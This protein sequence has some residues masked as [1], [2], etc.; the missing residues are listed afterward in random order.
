MA[1]RNSLWFRLPMACPAQGT[2][3]RRHDRSRHLKPSARPLDCLQ[4]GMAVLVSKPPPCVIHED[5]HILVVN[6]PAG[7]NTHSPAPYAG[8]GIYEWLRNRERRWGD[9]AIIHRLDKA[10]SGLMLFAKTPLAN[11][12]LTEQFTQRSVDKRYLFLTSEPPKETEFTVRASLLRAGEK[13][14][15]G[16]RGEP[17]ETRFRYLGPDREYYLFAAEPLTGRT[18]QIR[19]HAAFKGLPIVGDILYGGRPFARVCL[20]SESLSFQHPQSG[21]TISFREEPQ[22]FKNPAW[23][24]REA[25]IE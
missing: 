18:H 17:A 15:A 22:F 25:I 2:S 21:S 14:H 6:K 24:L 10:T 8:E 13:Y 11:K 5:E 4:G 7:L 20:H 3:G 1:G 16:N 19:V 9:L 12:S 23:T